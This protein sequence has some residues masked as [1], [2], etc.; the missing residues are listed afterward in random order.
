M[1]ETMKKIAIGVITGILLSHAFIVVSNDIR[2]RNQPG[3]KGMLGN[4]LNQVDFCND[5]GKKAS[6]HYTFDYGL[7]T[8][9][10]CK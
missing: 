8:Y 5:Y 1:N 6:L 10:S 2:L 3:G 4:A 7:Y 9:A